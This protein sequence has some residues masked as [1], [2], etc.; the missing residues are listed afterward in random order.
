MYKITLINMPF[1]NLAL[2]SIALTQLREIVKQRWGEEVRVR[3]LYLNQDFGK[4]FGLSTYNVIAGALQASNSGLGD[5]IFRQLAFP[6]LEDN[7][8][9]Y[10][11]RYFPRLDPAGEALKGFVLAKR[12][13]LKRFMEQTIQSYQLDQ[14][15]L[16]GLTSMFA[17][18]V[19][20]IALARM[21]KARN[22][23][24]ITIMGGAN[25]EAP[26]GRFLAKS[27]PALDYIASGPA[28]VSLP[29]LIECLMQGD[30]AATHSIRGLL[31][32]EN[33]SSFDAESA[34]GEELPIQVAVPLDYDSFLDD[35]A[36]NFPGGKL[37]PSL[38][39]ETSRGCWWG[40]RSHCTFCGLNGGTM[41]YRSLPSGDALNL[42]ESL[43]E[44]Y[45]DRCHRFESVDNIL[46]R[47][48]LRE[49]FP[50]L[51]PPPD[52]TIFYEVKADLKPKEMEILSAG[53]V[54]E[55]Q[56]GIEALNTSTLKLMRKGTTSFQNVVF[57]KNALRFGIR[58]AW[59]LLIGF[60][61]ESE[62]VYEKYLADIP[63][64]V[65]LPP[66]GGAFPVRFDRYSPYFVRAADYSLELEPYEFYGSIYPFPPE[67]LAGMAYYFQD[68]NYSARYLVQLASWQQKL[69][70]EVQRWT[71]RFSGRDGTARAALWLEVRDGHA[72]VL[73]RREAAPR[74]VRLDPVQQRIL[75]D[76]C[77]RA[78]GVDS[79]AERLGEEATRVQ[80]A[81]EELD[82]L[83]FV[84]RE[85]DRF[86]S[87][88]I[89]PLE[90]LSKEPPLVVGATA[91]PER[92]SER[93]PVVSH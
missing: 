58:P 36:R 55:I 85:D 13:G 61:G 78:S 30:R 11:P 10:F 66:P 12:T 41:A 20:S 27:V 2:P 86:V 38:T 49:V 1:A 44:R 90:W 82:G 33:A 19:A 26:M 32:A 3:I 6:D 69:V 63:R 15:N 88:V 28:L 79:I 68:Q 51:S 76:L 93:L 31:T 56:P 57:L 65:H 52:A 67:V 34:L 25:C 22:P 18:N 80:S 45:G 21:V 81:L 59:N 29:K 7:A 23:Q 40:E 83:G 64:L 16:I 87:V 71:S 39:F 4:Y 5:W 84:F 43:F 9:D 14:E 35:L 74:D 91:R 92:Q 70:A 48:Y 77:L 72:V 60:P 42:L 54:R 47:E 50:K 53:G 73:D 17:Q 37:E 46:P 75:Q 8:R 89:E 24:V 62:A